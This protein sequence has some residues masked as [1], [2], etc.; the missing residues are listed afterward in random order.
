MAGLLC[1]GALAGAQTGSYAPYPNPDAGYVTDLAD[2]LS[3]E[4]ERRLE[5]WLQQAE[6]RS[7]V[8]I[9]VV[10]IHSIS[11]YPRTR[12]GSIEEFAWALFNAYGVGNMPRNNG[13]LLLV[14]DRDRQARIEL[15]TGHERRR[16]NDVSRIMRQVI[17]PCL[18]KERYAAGVIQGTK[19]LAR[20]F[21]GI[22]FIPSWALWAVAGSIVALIPVSISLFRSGKRGWGWVVIGLIIILLLLLIRIRTLRGRLDS[23]SAAAGGLGG[24][25]GGFSGGGGAT[26]SW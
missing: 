26:G 9:V 24:F 19:E 22:F 16:N 7:G 25:G 3:D 1:L 11:D 5:G 21:G 23:D 8:E 20:T 6:K 18:R 14:A 10:T 17:M 2:L 15:G 4:Q 13:V 12:N